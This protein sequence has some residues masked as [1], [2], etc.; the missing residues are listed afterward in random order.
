[1]GDTRT[2]SVIQ[3]GVG[4]ELKILR[5]GDGELD[6]RQEGGISPRNNVQST[7]TENNE[8]QVPG[9]VPNEN[10]ELKNIASVSVTSYAERPAASGINLNPHP[11]NSQDD[12]DEISSTIDTSKK[13]SRA[14]SWRPTHKIHPLSRQTGNDNLAFDGTEALKGNG[15]IPGI[16]NHETPVPHNQEQKQWQFV[17]V[18]VNQT[19]ICQ[20]FNDYRTTDIPIVSGITKKHNFEKG[21]TSN[22]VAN[23][24]VFPEH[25]NSTFSEISSKLETEEQRR[26]RKKQEKR[27]RNPLLYCR[28]VCSR[29]KTAFGGYFCTI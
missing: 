26:E 23:G 5:T 19:N 29:P 17:E 21:F 13:K 1:M 25:R 7:G 28:F 20:V 12:K 11:T 2:S 4:G 18:S 24:R 10:K 3:I 8:H 22:G 6:N 15:S 14:E 27:D 16:G 9:V